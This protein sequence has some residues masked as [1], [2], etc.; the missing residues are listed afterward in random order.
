MTKNPFITAIVQAR[1]SSKRFPGKVMAEINGV[2]IIQILLERLK[3]CEILDEIIV[4]TTHKEE[5]D[6]LS[7]FL[8]KLGIKVFRGNENDVLSRFVEATQISKCNIVVRI[9]ADCP[10]IDPVIVGKVIKKFLS[11]NF[12]YVSNT[13]P[14]LFPD[15]MDVEVFSKKT[16]LLANQYS[17]LRKEREDHIRKYGDQGLSQLHLINKGLFE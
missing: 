12:D 17:S 10:L 8:N 16:L 9:T 11:G 14:P 6:C 4:A 3:L 5:D 13:D 1:M 7:D 2:P 15:G